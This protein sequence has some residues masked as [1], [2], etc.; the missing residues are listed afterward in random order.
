MCVLGVVALIILTS[1]VMS[2]YLSWN[3]CPY[4][5]KNNTILPVERPLGSSAS[6]E[7]VRPICGG[8]SHEIMQ[9]NFI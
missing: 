7:D 4:F 5:K 3:S 2:I 6:R 1:A 9:H 8:D